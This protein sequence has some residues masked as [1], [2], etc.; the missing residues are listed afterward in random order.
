M[1]PSD[2]PDKNAAPGTG[3]SPG[4][5]KIAAV[6]LGVAAAAL[7]LEIGLQLTGALGAMVRRAKAPAVA[8]EVRILCLGDSMTVVGGY[9]A[10]LEAELN[11]A[12]GPVH[13]SVI[14]RGQVAI[15]DMYVAEHLEEN[16]NEY[17]PDAVVVMIDSTAGFYR[18]LPQRRWW[19][20]FRIGR[21]IATAAEQLIQHRD[22]GRIA[23]G[24]VS[25]LAEDQDWGDAADVGE[26]YLIVG[27]YR[28]AAIFFKSA[29][30]VAEG[31]PLL[32]LRQAALALEKGDGKNGREILNRGTEEYPEDRRLLKC[33]YW[34][35]NIGGDPATAERLM[36][37]VVA[38]PGADWS[39]FSTL[40]Y[41]YLQKGNRAGAGDLQPHLKRAG[42]EDDRLL[43]C[44]A[45][46]ALFRGEDAEARAYFAKAD[47]LSDAR[48]DAAA[49]RR[50]FYKEIAGKILARKLTLFSMQYPVRRIAPLKKSLAGLEGVRFVDN[51]GVFKEALRKA[52]FTEIFGDQYGG[53]F[54]HLRPKGVELLVR[55]LAREVL[56]ADLRP[57]G[58]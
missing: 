46:L 21:L 5:Q 34:I 45:V 25:V 40:S 6:L 29:M 49:A 15:G 55:N 50:N 52:P 37:K 30:G 41:R 43:R 4:R 24:D 19:W 51:E 10:H 31:G 38:M 53:D 33:A 2:R 28:K 58:R 27:D 3:M 18:Q 54:G 44:Y 35:S 22:F 20:T 39:D 26:H 8:G 12:G 11:R 48:S 42:V 7:L 16:L 57:R 13:Y 47:A 23:S 36:K 14:D 17:R 9:P 1:S 32:R 56:K